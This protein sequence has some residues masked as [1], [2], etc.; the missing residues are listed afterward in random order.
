MN[1][2]PASITS[3]TLAFRTAQA[4]TLTLPGAVTLG[5]GGVLVGSQVGAKPRRSPA[6]RSPRPRATWWS[7][8]STPAS[9][10]SVRP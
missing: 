3:D 8:S 2:A 10:R 9:L 4:N 1:P 5:A 6:A 7:S